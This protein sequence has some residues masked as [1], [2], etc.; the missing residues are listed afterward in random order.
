MS[1]SGFA[2]LVGRPNVGKSTLT[3]AL[4]GSAGGDHLRRGRRP[5]GTPSAGWST[6]T[7]TKSILVDT[8]G[9]HR[10]RTLLGR[11]L[12]DL[13]LATLTEVDV[14]VL[15]LPADQRIGP[16]DRFIAE[17]LQ[18]LR[19]QRSGR[20]RHQGR[21]CGPVTSWRSGCSRPATSPDQMALEIA[22]FVPVSAPSTGPTSTSWPACSPG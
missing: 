12:N 16:G 7:T 14:V 11:R 22:D 20:R 18:D 19:R 3:N 8:P 17:R 10:P 4:V 6:S 15:C 5:P 9:I 1:R 21:C 13:V 2:I